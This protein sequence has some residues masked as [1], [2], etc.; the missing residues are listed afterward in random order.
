MSIAIIHTRHFFYDVKKAVLMGTNGYTACQVK[1]LDR[2]PFSHYNIGWNRKKHVEDIVR[3]GL[4]IDFYGQ[5]LTEKQLRILE[6]YYLHNLSLAE[7]ADEEGISRQ[8]VH[9]LLQRSVKTLEQFE[10]KLVLVESYTRN[11]QK[12]MELREKMEK[13]KEKVSGEIREEI[14]NI[15]SGIDHMMND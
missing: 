9:D 12:F 10:K 8:A 5:L 6:S 1:I 11:Q 14:I 4:L 7:I 2:I 15:I 13:I 3:I